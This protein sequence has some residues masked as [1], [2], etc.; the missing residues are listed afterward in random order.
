MN[1]RIIPFFSLGFTHAHYAIYLR[2]EPAHRG[3]FALWRWDAPFTELLCAISEGE[4]LGRR[5]VGWIDGIALKSKLYV[6]WLFWNGHQTAKDHGRLNSIWGKTSMHLQHPTS[7]WNLS[8]RV[9]RGAEDR[10]GGCDGA[11]Q[12]LCFEVSLLKCLCMSLL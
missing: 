4:L 10:C 12:A 11:R 2:P 9:T 7:H 8:G 1:S 3:T 6:G 5:W